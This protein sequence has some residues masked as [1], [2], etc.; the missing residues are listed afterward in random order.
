MVIGARGR[1]KN[2]AAAAAA[3]KANPN[4]IGTEGAF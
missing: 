1:M 3:E 2:A 4:F